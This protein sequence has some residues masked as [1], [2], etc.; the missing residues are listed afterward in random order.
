MTDWRNVLIVTGGSTPQVVTET[1]YALAR[2]KPS[3]FVPKK[4]ICAITEGV[5]D[6]FGVR[7]TAALEALRSQLKLSTDWNCASQL[8]HESKA[9]LFIEFPRF[10]DGSPVVDIRTDADATLFGDFIAEIVRIETL[11]SS[12]RLHLS[13]SGG[14][15]TMSFHG[16]AAMSLFGRPQD[17]LSHVLV[18]PEEF[19]Q[20]PDFWF[21][22]SSTTIVRQRDGRPL[23]ASKAK[24]KLTDIPFLRIRDRLPSALLTQSM[25]YASHV[26]RAN[27]ALGITPLGLE[28]IISERRVHIGTVADFRLSNTEFAL[29]QLMAEWKLHS[30]EGA[31]PNGIGRAHFGWLTASMFR[32]P[33]FYQPNPVNRFLQIYAETFKTSTDQADDMLNT[34][35]AQPKNQKQRQANEDRFAQWKARLISTLQKEIRQTELADRFGAPLAPI[36][37]RSG[38]EG[39]RGNRVVFGLRLQPQEISIRS[40]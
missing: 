10:S 34:I 27:A 13:I 2:R 17:Q 11:D 22:A 8:L 9:G 32:N 6:A 18:E 3:P 31:G 35:T 1:I 30:Y 20:C 12:A 16:G 14:R 15:R 38:V 39:I 7:F 26:A 33:E 36:K 21:P 40:D 5:R 24:I 25:D 28:L 23:D 4:I 19:E 29:Y 37:V